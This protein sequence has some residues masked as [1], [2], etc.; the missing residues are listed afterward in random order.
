[1]SYYVDLDEETGLHCV[2]CSKTGKAVAFYTLKKDAENR[3]RA[4]DPALVEPMTQA[5][6]GQGPLTL[7]ALH[8]ELQRMGV[9]TNPAS[10]R[11]TLAVLSEVFEK[12]VLSRKTFL[13]SV[14]ALTP[15]V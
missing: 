15:R 10:V 1:M 4:Y 3:V 8:L 2:F 6:R 7:V 5:L 14:R 9:E 11:G 12:K 13:Y